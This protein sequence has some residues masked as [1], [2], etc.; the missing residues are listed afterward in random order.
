MAVTSAQP[1]AP[2]DVERAL[3]EKVDWMQMLPAYLR[4]IEYNYRWVGGYLA[5]PRPRDEVVVL[6]G[7]HQP[8]AIVTGEGA[9]WDVPVHIVARDTPLLQRFVDRGF[10]PG[11]T[12]ARPV[13]GGMHELTHW[14]LE[15]FDAPPPQGAAAASAAPRR[16]AP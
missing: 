11:L 13:L 5:L 6:V 2:A 16:N 7:D 12:P 15:A 4:M 14:M 10:R 1:F 9:P 3:Q 8:A